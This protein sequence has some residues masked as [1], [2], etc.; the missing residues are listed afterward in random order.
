MN[1]DFN[2]GQL[3]DS[4]R[5]YLQKLGMSS[6]VA[7][8][9]GLFSGILCGATAEQKK[10]KF[11]WLS[12]LDLKPEPGDMLAQEA[13]DVVD[14]FFAATLSALSS[15][16]LDFQLAVEEGVDLNDRLA[17]F[18]IWVQGFLY[19]MGLSRREDFNDCSEQVQEFMQD[20]VEIS[21][22]EQYE[23]SDQDEDE[24]ALFEL[25]EYVR[26]GTLLVFEELNPVAQTSPIDMSGVEN[27]IH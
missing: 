21:N 1:L 23:L 24:H 7:E 13:M 12:L 22:A 19:G 27:S 9:H 17:D 14:E 26:V 16:D 2:D 5:P 11:F 15:S 10:Q 20:L 3:V 4:L 18:S 8:A 25:I 6:S